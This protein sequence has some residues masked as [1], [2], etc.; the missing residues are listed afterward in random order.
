TASPITVYDTI[1]GGSTFVT[2]GGV[3]RTFMGEPLNLNAPTNYI[4]GMDV[5]LSSTVPQSYNKVVLQV[6]F[7]NN[8]DPNSTPL[9]IFS[10]PIGSVHTFDVGPQ[11]LINNLYPFSFT[12]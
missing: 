2:S 6:Q 7:W 5:I 11:V 3:P 12:F 10:N 1:S 4:T 8:F 9:P